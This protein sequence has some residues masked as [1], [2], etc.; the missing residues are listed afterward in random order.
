MCSFFIVVSYLNIPVFII[1]YANIANLTSNFSLV[2]LSTT[3]SL[4]RKTL[5]SIKYPGAGT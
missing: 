3:I 4:M 1:V 5:S 2:Q